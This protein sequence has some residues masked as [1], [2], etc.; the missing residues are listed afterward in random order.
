[1]TDAEFVKELAILIKDYISGM[2]EEELEE[3]QAFANESLTEH[4]NR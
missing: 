4:R 1:M 2:S 3:V